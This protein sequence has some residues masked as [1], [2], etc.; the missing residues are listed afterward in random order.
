[1][2]LDVVWIFGRP[3]FNPKCLKPGRENREEELSILLTVTVTKSKPG[4]NAEHKTEV[5]TMVLDFGHD[6]ERALT[7]SSLAVDVAMEFQPSSQPAL[8]PSPKHVIPAL[9]MA[10]N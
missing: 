10:Y 6:L 3:T 4:N 2:G 1:L 9:Q 5:V 8:N 7:A